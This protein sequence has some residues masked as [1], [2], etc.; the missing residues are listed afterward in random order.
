MMLK[1]PKTIAVVCKCWKIAE[2]DFRKDVRV[3]NPD[4]NEVSVTDQFYGKFNGT[5][6][7]ASERRWIEQAFIADIH[8]AFPDISSNGQS[9]SMACGLIATVTLHGQGTERRTG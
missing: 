8:A 2:E 3:N 1:I 7:M 4:L 6:R 9:A 5:L